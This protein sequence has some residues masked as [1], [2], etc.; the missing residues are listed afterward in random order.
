MSA[1]VILETPRL[2]FRPLAF[3]DADELLALYSDP[4]VMRF[5][6]GTRSRRQVLDEIEEC[7]RCYERLGFHFWATIR[8]A[9]QRFI[10]RCGLLLQT[11][12]GREEVEV[13]YMLA[14]S[15][16]NQGLGT[17]AA[18]AIRDHGFATLDCPR[19]I[20]LIAPGNE[21]SKRVAAKNGMRYVKHVTLNGYVDLLYAVDRSGEA[22][23]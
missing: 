11:I 9:D 22:A 12:E 5:F 8:K 4:E 19:L 3:D 1:S 14:R 15:C 17:E 21:A 13:A 23:Q 20:S 2:L 16:W 18:R 6:E 10:G 7:R